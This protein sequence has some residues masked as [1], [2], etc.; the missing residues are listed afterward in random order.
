MPAKSGEEKERIS[1][2]DTDVQTKHS[3]LVSTWQHIFP[4]NTYQKTNKLKHK[5]KQEE[6]EF[7]ADILSDEWLRENVKM[8][9]VEMSQRNKRKWEDEE[10]CTDFLSD[11][12]LRENVE[13]EVAETKPKIKLELVKTESAECSSNDVIRHARKG[14]EKLEVPSKNVP[15]VPKI[16][17]RRKNKDKEQ[18]KQSLVIKN[19]DVSESASS[20]LCTLTCTVCSSKYSSWDEFKKH[21]KSK[22][23]TTLV[24]KTDF[25]KYLTNAVVHVCRICSEK[26]LCDSTHLGQHYHSKHKMGLSEYRKQF[27]CETYIEKREKILING[28]LSTNIIGDLCTFQCQVCAQTFN[29]IRAIQIHSKECCPNVQA[30]FWVD[31]IT[32]VITHKCNICSKPMLCDQHIIM[33]HLRHSHGY[34]NLDEYAKKEGIT[35]ITNKELKQNLTFTQSCKSKSP[36]KLRKTLYVLEKNVRECINAVNQDQNKNIDSE[37]KISLKTCLA[38]INQSESASNKFHTE[39]EDIKALSIKSASKTWTRPKSIT[40]QM[41]ELMKKNAEVSESAAT[42]LCTFTCPDCL[43]NYRSRISFEL[44]MKSS[45]KKHIKMSNIESCRFMTKATV[46]MCQICSEMVFCEKNYLK[47]HFS[48][49]HKLSLTS[50]REKYNCGIYKEQLTKLLESGKL[51]E[52]KVGSLCSF[53]CPKC[54][55]TFK[56]LA[57]FR[58][59]KHNSKICLEDVK[60]HLWVDCLHGTIITHKCKICSKLLLCDLE[61]IRNHLSHH[62][63]ITS[64]TQYV[65]QTGCSN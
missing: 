42:G 15:I 46:H 37:V 17:K 3:E 58:M 57:N 47:G 51:S 7:N 50:Y 49:K 38:K 35:Y 40:V 54:F 20:G 9:D 5:M 63:G 13:M 4:K 39:F 29:G 64:I 53:K 23:N 8:E 31:C 45:H 12:W 33:S 18:K 36:E 25:E 48:N 41:E 59:H 2:F 27:C 43:A 30:K 34:K 44:H 65:K 16:K 19:A 32:K 60:A 10:F 21:M 28:A 14:D 61:P 55:S 56:G 24:R 11:E 6:E 62:H 1:Q 22:H 26:I 52:N